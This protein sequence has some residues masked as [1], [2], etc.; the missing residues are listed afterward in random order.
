MEKRATKEI[1]QEMERKF[2][3][4]CPSL[5]AC[6]VVFF[7]IVVACWFGMKYSSFNLKMIVIFG[8]LIFCYL[9]AKRSFCKTQQV[10]LRHFKDLV[11][12]LEEI[13]KSISSLE[14]EYKKYS[15]GNSEN[16]QEDA[17]EEKK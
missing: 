9:V 10:Y 2:I 13:D 15:Q 16:G 1:I 3:K 11:E 17:V 4:G 7:L 14:K 5:L 8:S 12:D 6:W